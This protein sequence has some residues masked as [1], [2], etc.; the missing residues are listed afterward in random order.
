MLVVGLRHD[1]PCFVFVLSKEGAHLV[2]DRGERGLQ[3]GLVRCPEV[4]I[5]VRGRREVTRSQNWCLSK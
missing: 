1:W 4:E 3:D 2:K 5:S